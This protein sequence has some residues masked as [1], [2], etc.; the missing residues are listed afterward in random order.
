MTPQPSLLL[1]PDRGEE[2]IPHTNEEI[3]RIHWSPSIMNVL[4]PDEIIFQGRTMLKDKF[5]CKTRSGGEVYAVSL[6][7]F[8]MIAAD[9]VRRRYTIQAQGEEYHWVLRDSGEGSPEVSV[10]ASGSH[11]ALKLISL[12]L[13]ARQRVGSRNNSYCPIQSKGRG[14]RSQI[15]RRYDH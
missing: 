14:L 11:R 4:V 8:P 3:A 10:T 13:S 1:P 5:I 12:D 7:I 15:G 6:M 9:R 2:N